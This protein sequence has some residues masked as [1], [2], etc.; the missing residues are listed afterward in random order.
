MRV[1]TSGIW[2]ESRRQLPTF[3]C[4]P[5]TAPKLKTCSGAGLADRTAEPNA[6]CMFILKLHF[7]AGFQVSRH[8]ILD[9]DAL[10]L[11]VGGHA[12]ECYCSSVI[13]VHPFSSRIWYFGYLGGN[14]GYIRLHAPICIRSYPVSAN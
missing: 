14:S 13:V 6:G 12:T 3:P 2:S 10:R 4:S 7:V 9:F 11:Q 5:A 8:H 1:P